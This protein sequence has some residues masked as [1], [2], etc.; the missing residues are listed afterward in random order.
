MSAIQTTV[1]LA[2]TIDGKISSVDP[3]AGGNA[4]AADQ[5]H[6]EYEVSFAD[7]I[8]VGAGT[9]RAGDVVFSIRNPEL[10]A[11]REARGQSRQPIVC[12]V[13][14]SLDLS[15]DFPFLSE[16]IE[17]WIF[18][19]RAGLERSSDTTTLQKLAELIDLG[20]TDLD[21]DRAY[22]LMAERGIHK[23]VALGGG[24][25]TASLVKAGRIDD[26]WLTIWPVIYGGKDAPTPVEGE[27]FISTAAP[28]VELVETRQVGSELFLHYQ[29]IK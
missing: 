3:Q 28:H 5:A 18:T 7:L 2:M 19:T 24:Y 17:R 11:A 1:V 29:T 14:G 25:L 9:I 4:D 22:S 15:L 8:L 26:W 13:S 20:D 21:W 10:L 16:D 6:V 23:V 27:G 12:V